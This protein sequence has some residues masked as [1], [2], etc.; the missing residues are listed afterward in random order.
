MISMGGKETSQLAPRRYCTSHTQEWKDQDLSPQ[1]CS[2]IQSKTMRYELA[3]HSSKIRQLW[4]KPMYAIVTSMHS[5]WAPSGKPWHWIASQSNQWAFAEV[6]NRLA[7]GLEY[8]SYIRVQDFWKKLRWRKWAYQRTDSCQHNQNYHIGVPQMDNAELAK[9]KLL[10]VV[11]I[12][13]KWANRYEKRRLKT[14]SVIHA[15]LHFAIKRGFTHQNN[16]SRATARLDSKR[17]L[18]KAALSATTHAA[19][20][21]AEKLAQR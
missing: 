9:N 8:R 13:R 10:K 12:H 16:D 11:T 20:H 17:R 1:L 6:K 3:Q 18:T 5:T 2:P 19:H 7:W 21:K 15:G 14:P 4:T